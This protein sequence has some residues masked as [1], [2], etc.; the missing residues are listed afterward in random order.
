MVLLRIPNMNE[1]V[2]ETVNPSPEVTSPAS[3]KTLLT[4]IFIVLS[5]IG[6]ALIAFLAFYVNQRMKQPLQPV[7][8]STPTPVVVQISPTLIS[9][10][11]EF[12]DS[13]TFYYIAH[14]NLSS[15]IESYTITTS[16]KETVFTPKENSSIQAVQVLNEQ[17]L[18]FGMCE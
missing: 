1:T 11:I 7:V 16:K 14:E 5:I 9:E 3:N 8:I 6:I 17:T 12:P 10:T 2:N 4:G 15:S 18:G 13:G